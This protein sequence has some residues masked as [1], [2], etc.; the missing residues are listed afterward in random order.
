MSD[1][2][3]RATEYRDGGSTLLAAFA[4]VYAHPIP[5]RRAFRA[6]VDDAGR[7]RALLILR[8]S[9][10]R[11]GAVLSTAEARDV[12]LAEM[13]AQ[14]HGEH[15]AARTRPILREV[16]RTLREVHAFRS[17]RDRR[18][19]A[20]TRAEAVR[21][22]VRTMEDQ[23]ERIAQA[24]AKLR[25]EAVRV[26]QRPRDAVRAMIRYGK[27]TNSVTLRDGLKADPEWFGAVRR[28]PRADWL[29]WL[30]F[31]DIAQAREHLTAVWS[32]AGQYLYETRE[33]FPSN[34]Q[35][36]AARERAAALAARVAA[37]EAEAPPEV[38]TS[39]TV[40]KAAVRLFEAMRLIERRASEAGPH[41]ARQL[42]AMLPQGA[43]S[44]VKEAVRLAVLQD[45]EGRGARER[46][47][48]RE[49]EDPRKREDRGGIERERGGYER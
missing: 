48:G 13:A 37:M 10:E 21:R 27:R 42:R 3:P 46:Q 41:V 33:G 47:Q 9:P 12:E 8:G 23:R 44:L 29:G 28:S 30:G 31:T 26:F 35:L 19:G 34:H 16:A 39:T 22:E 6:A 36:Q 15:R 4:A 17:Y 5:A 18:D 45:E 40:R 25:A 43:D 38:D 32:A 7:L 24:L 20:Q 1:L 14:E 2:R 11:F 49:R